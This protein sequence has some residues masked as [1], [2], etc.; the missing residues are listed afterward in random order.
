MHTDLRLPCIESG[1]VIHAAEYGGA[2]IRWGGCAA[3]QSDFKGLGSA[4]VPVLRSAK[5]GNTVIHG[6][7]EPVKRPLSCST[8]LAICAS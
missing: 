4:R 3:Y 7:G 6:D 8:R 5:E 1:L 2:T